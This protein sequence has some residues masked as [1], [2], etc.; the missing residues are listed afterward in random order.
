[1]LARARRFAEKGRLDSA[2]EALKESIAAQGEDP[3]LR[4]E[5]SQILVTSG[6]SREAADGLR[7]FLKAH[8]GEHRRVCDF[9]DW[10]RAHHHE[11]QALHEVLGEHHVSRR[12][13]GPALESLERVDR[14]GLQ[15]LLESRLATLQRFL[16]KSGAATPKSAVPLLYFAALAEEALQDY[17]KAVEMYRRILAASPGEVTQ[18]EERLKGII[19]R[20]HRSAPLR[21]ALAEVY[22]GAGEEARALEE[23]VQMVE[24]DPK[25]ATQAATA[26]EKIAETSRDAAPA[27]WALCRVRRREDRLEDLL[28]AAGRLIALDAHLDDLRGLLEALLADGKDDPRLQLLIGESARRGKKLPRATSAFMAAAMHSAVDIQAR[29]REGLERILEDNPAERRVLEALSDQHLRDGRFDDCVAMLDRLGS[30]DDQGA[31]TALSRLQTLL[32]A[33]PGHASAEGLIERLAPSSGNPA[34]ATAFLRRRVRA[35][36]EAARSAL[37]S[38]QRL[39]AQDPKSAEI[40]HATAEAHAACGEFAESWQTLRPLVDATMGPDPTLLHLLVLIGGSG[41]GLCHEVSEAFRTMAPALAATPEGSFAIGEMSARAGDMTAALEAFRAAAAF[42]PA[43]AAEVIDAIRSLSPAGMIGESAVALGEALLE[44]GDFAGAA[45]ILASSTEL[46]PSATRL[47]ARLEGALRN[48][49]E[50]IELRV[51][52]ASIL[53]AGGRAA[54]GREVIDDGIRRGGES[55]SPVLHLANGDAWVA[56]GNLTEAVRAYSRAMSQDKTTAS[57]AARKLGKVLDID[58]GHPTA[59]LALGRALLLD[60]RPREGVNA[61]LTAW[62]I[63]PSLGASILKDLGY[64]TRSFPLEPQVDLARSQILLGQGEVEAASDALGSALRTSPSIA[65]EVLMRLEALTRSHPSCAR[66]HYHAAHA[67]LVKKRFREASAAFAAA[68]EHEPKLAEPAAAGLA[69]V[70]RASPESPEP[71]IARARL[72]ESQGNVMSAAEAYRAAAARGADPHLALD[73]L[74]RLAAGTG[75][76]RGRAMLAFG[77]AARD[78]ALPGESA[79]ALTEAARIA[80]EHIDEIREELDGLVALD[81]ANAEALIARAR[82]ALGAHDGAT[83]LADAE[84]LVGMPGRAADAAAIA[85]DAAATGGDAGRCGW[86]AARALFGDGRFDEAA[87]ELDRCMEGSAPVRRAEMCLLRARIERRRGD[88]A[89]SRRLTAEAEALSGDR[90]TFLSTL[91]AE[92]IAAARFAAQTVATASDRWRAL[93]AALDLG[94]ADAAEKIADALSLEPSRPGDDAGAAGGAAEV[95]ARIACLRGR[96]ADAAAILEREAPSILKAHALSRSGRVRDAVVCLARMT[97]DGADP[98]TATRRLMLELAADEIL[99]DAPCLVAT[100]RLRFPTDPEGER[101]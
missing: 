85:R 58:V 78:L 81:P 31:A 14:K 33:R 15:L 39:L 97:P 67:W 11:T 79:A 59:H 68:A 96:Y 60:G 18:V 22:Q 5:L 75:P 34:L 49:P 98:S 42:S 28:R 37:A 26:I 74:R 9:V 24:V 47:L 38:L 95:R 19:A 90:E 43:A 16:D 25:T 89:A 50:N 57:E 62:S 55:A 94:D 46:P 44:A 12:E 63:R 56:D 17:P 7:G 88:V 92:A 66:A 86:L 100:T 21:A 51:A 20:N 3:I 6:Q 52:L 73:P 91:H 71:H 27:L 36:D 83:A 87:A 84:K 70:M 40:R 32:L 82:V 61:L 35:G 8:P 53:S 2:A 23:Y 30:L 54:R 69:M 48:S 76:S 65:T 4:I 93:R 1:M 29:A 77:A 10:A 13:F 72:Y 99:G 41:P 80:P 101:E 64:A 45:A